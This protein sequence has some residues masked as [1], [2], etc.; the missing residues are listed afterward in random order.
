M[1][2]KGNKMSTSAILARGLDLCAQISQ[3]SLQA[4]RLAQES[5]RLVVS[6]DVYCDLLEYSLFLQGCNGEQNPTLE[7]F[8]LADGLL[9]E[10]NGKKLSVQIDFFLPNNSIII[11][12][13]VRT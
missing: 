6:F 9:F 4:E 12:P 7:D 5:D 1:A 2:R 13:S 11:S 3:M 8:L 10:T